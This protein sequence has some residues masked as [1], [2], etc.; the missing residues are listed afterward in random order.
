LNNLY[1]K[2]IGLV[3]TF[4]PLDY[5]AFIISFILLLPILNFLKEGIGNVLSDGF[6]LGITG[7]EE[8][9][10]S[11]KVLLLTSF[12]GGGLGI[13]N[14]WLL[15]NCEFRFRKTLRLCQLIPLAAPAYLITAILQDLGSIFGYQITGMWW[16][17]LILSISTYPYV[18]ILTNESFNKS[19][20]NQILASRGLGVGPWKSFFRIALPMALPALVTGISLMCMEVMN[21]LG[22]FEL[23]NISSISTGITENWIIDGNPAGAIGLSLCALIIVFSLIFIEK[24]SRLKTR[25]W[26]ENPSLINS[27]GW[28]LNGLRSFFAILFSIFP[29][30]F[31]LGIPL[32]WVTLNLDQIQRGLTS[33]L[34]MLTFRT[35]GLG[36]IASLLAII[37]SLLISLASRWNKSI[38]LRSITFTSGIGYAIPGTVLAIS[39]LTL[40]N[41]KFYFFPVILLIWGYTCRFLTISKGSIDSALER[42]S[43]NIDEAATG[44]GASK[45]NIIKNIQ[46][47]LLKEPIFIGT[48][49]VFVDTIK[50]L[51]IT[52]LLRPFDFD[53]LSVRIYQYAGDERMAEAILPAILITILG[54]IASSTLIPSLETKET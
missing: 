32:L 37:F 38:F 5:I 17:I 9:Y 28:K 13:I 22:T 24:F 36:A 27:Q 48:L 34:L 3:K 10:G 49:L 41:S 33:E 16:G 30:L 42:I 19:G 43:P 35:I 8:I 45:S 2:F 14:G 11:V 12:F 4:K 39:L 31:S 51:P 29:A 26:S 6:S 18:F 7:K 40:V 15:S 50:E 52:F 23:L 47:P 20:L 53:T 25:R 1:L 44:L 21:E 54:L 46:I